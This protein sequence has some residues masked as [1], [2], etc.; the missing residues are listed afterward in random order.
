MESGGV[1]WSIR[2]YDYMFEHKERIKEAF[3]VHDTEKTGKVSRDVFVQV[4]SVEGFQ[5][6]IETDEMKS[7]IV[8]HEKAK[9][10]IDYELF[11]SG[12]KYITKLYLVASFEPKKKK[13]KK[14]K[15]KGGKGKK[16]R[17]IMPICLMNEGPRTD[18]GEPPVIY[19]PQVGLPTISNI[20]FRQKLSF[21]LIRIHFKTSIR[22]ILETFFK[23][24]LIFNFSLLLKNK[25][26]H[27]YNAAF[28]IKIRFS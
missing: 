16:T 15:G 26:I 4:V 21:V 17:I 5:N 10:E 14:K 23:P 6:L 11:L 22:I 19:Q 2:L 8:S 1:N 9:D 25:H 12:K 20:Y 3:L 7:L 13:S 24:R 18:G 28:L 27:E